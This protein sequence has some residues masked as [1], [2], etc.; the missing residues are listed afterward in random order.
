MERLGANG[1][2][3]VL[4]GLLIECYNSALG[5]SRVSSWGLRKSEF[6]KHATERLD[7]RKPAPHS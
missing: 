6:C 1:Q 4:D 3:T 5:P 7:Q 2:K